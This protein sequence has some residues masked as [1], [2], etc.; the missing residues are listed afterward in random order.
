MFENPTLHSG[1]YLYSLEVAVHRSTPRNCVTAEALCKYL[2]LCCN[3][4][5]HVFK[6]FLCPP[7]WF[8]SNQVLFSDVTIFVCVCFS[9]S[10]CLIALLSFWW[11]W[12]RIE[13][14]RTKFAALATRFLLWWFKQQ[15]VITVKGHAHRF[16]NNIWC[17][18]LSIGGMTKHNIVRYLL[19][20]I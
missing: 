10:V 2:L 9:L 4:N 16:E 15:L 13:W 11:Q 19:Y 12:H 17:L 7:T 6:T 3:S 20:K 18:Q 8:W 1:T 14:I 5:E